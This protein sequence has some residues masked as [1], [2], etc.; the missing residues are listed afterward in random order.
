M[1]LSRGVCTNDSRSI[2]HIQKVVAVAACREV[3]RVAVA[4]CW[5]DGCT[6]NH[7]TEREAPVAGGEDEAREIEQHQ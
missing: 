6:G 1:E 2:F 7:R 4:D 3:G 5:G